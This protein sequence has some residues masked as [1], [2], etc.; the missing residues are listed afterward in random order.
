LP[1]NIFSV[2][3]DNHKVSIILEFQEGIWVATGSSVPHSVAIRAVDNKI[4]IRLHFHVINIAVMMDVHGF[5]FNDLIIFV[6]LDDDFLVAVKS[7]FIN[8]VLHVVAL[9][10]IVKD[11]LIIL[12]FPYVCVSSLKLDG[13]SHAEDSSQSEVL[14]KA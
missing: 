6:L 8:I 5:Q 4:T 1:D 11:D 2:L 13:A 3:L 14:G 7:H 12:S 10:T 9:I